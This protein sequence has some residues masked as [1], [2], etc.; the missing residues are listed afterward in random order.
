M[1]RIR[2]HLRFVLAIMAVMG[3]MFGVFVSSTGAQEPA[4]RQVVTL[5]DQPWSCENVAVQPFLEGRVLGVDYFSAGKIDVNLDP[6]MGDVTPLS[7]YLGPIH[8]EFSADY[9]SIS[10]TADP[11]YAVIVAIVKGG[12]AAYGYLY[13]PYAVSDTGLDSPVNQG[14]NIPTISNFSFCYVEIPV[15]THYQ[16]CS[17]GYWKQEQHLWA[18]QVDPSTPFMD[19][20]EYQPMGKDLTLKGNVQKEYT[21]ASL[22]FVISNPSIF[23]GEMTEMVADYLS[24][25]ALDFSGDPA[26]RYFYDEY[27][28]LTHDCPLGIDPGQ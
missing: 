10:F 19:V 18:W 15:E 11:G 1:T 24:V 6:A 17:P 22:L 20:F 3:M 9:T 14:G 2:H 12:P 7:G 26:D 16:W 8:F 23:G 13:T 21:D 25:G 28:V 27:G 4:S 5:T